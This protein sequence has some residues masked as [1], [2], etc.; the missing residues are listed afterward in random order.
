[1]MERS[2]K[3]EGAIE[4][5]FIQG[6]RLG[7]FLFFGDDGMRGAFVILDIDKYIFENVRLVLTNL[8]KM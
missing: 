3:V 6:N 1:M 5:M 4:G 7:R 2:A 8:G